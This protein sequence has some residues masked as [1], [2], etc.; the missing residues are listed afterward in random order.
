[1]NIR[2]ATPSD[3]PAIL[4]IEHACPAAAHWSPAEYA[5]VFDAGSPPRILLVSEESTLLGFILVRTI[6]PEWE[7]ENIAVSPDARQRGIGA[8]LVDAIL[9]QARHRH[10][11][12][13]HLEV[14]ASNAAARVLYLRSGFIETGHRPAYY[15][16]PLE[17]A[18]LYRFDLRSGLSPAP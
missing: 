3:I 9:T 5:H 11:E 15:A 2:P 10:A 6:S 14:R 17:D 1:M 4:A 7:L 16:N 18:V 13:I 8:Q 12:S